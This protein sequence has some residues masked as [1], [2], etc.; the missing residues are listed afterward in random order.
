MTVVLQ[1]FLPTLEEVLN[2]YLGQLVDYQVKFLTPTSTAETNSTAS[3]LE[4]DIQI[5]DEK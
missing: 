1:D 3:A 4:L 2:S 5:I